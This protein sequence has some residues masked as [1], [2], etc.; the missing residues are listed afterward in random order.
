MKRS[1]FFGLILIFAACKSGS[2]NEAQQA[3]EEV[4]SSAH[5]DAFN[6]SFEKILTHYYQL[7]DAFVASDTEKANQVAT[8]LIGAADSLNLDELKKADT[9]NIIVSTAKS[10]TGT[11]SSEGKG[12]LGETDIEG[13]RKE[14]QMISG[15]LFD[16][17][18]TVRYDRQKIYLLNCPMAFDQQG[19]DWLSNSPDVHNPYFGAKMPDCGNVKDSIVLK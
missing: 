5:S 10:Y 6:Q 13:K 8:A 3:A 18:R 16:L 11:I 12:L 2:K 1:L 9:S 7:R 17:I 4:K 19:A 14:F 15:A